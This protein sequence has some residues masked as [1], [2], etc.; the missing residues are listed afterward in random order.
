MAP[1][2]P[3][4][5]IL[6]LRRDSPVLKSTDEKNPSTPQAGKTAPSRDQQFGMRGVRGHLV[7]DNGT[8]LL[9]VRGHGRGMGLA[10][11]IHH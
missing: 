8:N 9:D 5:T 3:C 6:A 4:L 10:T 7:I 11:P 1:P 2:A